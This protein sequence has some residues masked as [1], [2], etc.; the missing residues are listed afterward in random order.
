MEDASWE[1]CGEGI[2][3]FWIKEGRGQSAPGQSERREAGRRGWG[4][5]AGRRR[6][7]QKDSVQRGREGGAL[8]FTRGDMFSLSL[9][10]N[11]NEWILLIFLG[12]RNW[13]G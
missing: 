8:G 12:S 6:T 1:T 9:A 7:G 11:S 13:G 4:R 5:H 2:R 10:P 3:G